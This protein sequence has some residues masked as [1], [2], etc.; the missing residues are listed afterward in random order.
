MVKLIK[1]FLFSLILLSAGNSV[2][3][4]QS[5][6]V[7]N[8]GTEGNI[9]YVIYKNNIIDVFNKDS[10]EKISAIQAD[11]TKTI[12][13]VRITGTILH[14]AYQGPTDNSFTIDLFNIQS[15]KKI[16]DRTIQHQN[17][18]FM[19][20]P[21]IMHCILYLMYKDSTIDLFDINSGLKINTIHANKNKTIKS[22]KILAELLFVGYQDNSSDTFDIFT[23]K[24]TDQDFK[25]CNDMF[26]YDPN[27]KNQSKPSKIC[28]VCKQKA[29]KKCLRW[30]ASRII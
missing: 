26:V 23:G 20:A 17:I 21:T 9:S 8:T 16:N 7:I 4:M 25:Y 2:L 27:K 28:S 19:H 6:K 10:H 11:K 18:V 3:G 29:G 13:K 5:K 15:A 22:G 12:D 14:V 1:C 30:M 24:T